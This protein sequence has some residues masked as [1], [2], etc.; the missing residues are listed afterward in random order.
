MGSTGAGGLRTGTPASHGLHRNVTRLTDFEDDLYPKRFELLKAAA[1]R[2]IRID[3][4][5]EDQ[6]PRS[7]PATYETLKRNEDTAAQG[8][9]LRH[10]R[11][12]MNAPKDFEKVTA[13]LTR[14]HVDALLLTGQAA[15]LMRK[16][17]GEFAIHQRLPSM[18][19]VRVTAS[20]GNDA[21][22]VLRP[23][24]SLSGL[25]CARYSMTTRSI[26]ATQDEDGQRGRD[27]AAVDPEGI[28]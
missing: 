3:L 1:P 8:L 15:Y 28:D 9:G 19:G 2:T 10:L 17:L 27:G 11:L 16:E 25:T 26:Y 14:E 12:P 22:T 20:G 7:G 6:S 23:Q 18:V 24:V 13:A 4:V 21:V 5:Q